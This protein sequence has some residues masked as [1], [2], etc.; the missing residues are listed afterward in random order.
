MDLAP[1]PQPGTYVFLNST[2]V[3]ASGALGDLIDM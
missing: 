1:A 3:S 2:S